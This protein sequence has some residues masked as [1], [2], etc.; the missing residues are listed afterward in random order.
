MFSTSKGNITYLIYIHDEF[1]KIYV[2]MIMDK[3]YEGHASRTALRIVVGLIMLGLLLADSVQAATL[4]VCNSGC[5]YSSIQDAIDAS[6]SGDT[7]LVQNGT[8]YENVNVYKQLT[9]RGIGM[10]EVYPWESGSTITLSANGIILE[11]FAETEAGVDIEAG[12]KVTSNNNILIGNNV[13]N[14]N[15]GISLQYSS[16]NKLIGNSVSNNAIGI[17]LW[18]S[19]SNMLSDNNVSNNAYGIYLGSSGNNTLIGNNV[20]NSYNRGIYLWYSNV[21]T[22]SSNNV[23][24]NYNKSVSLDFSSSNKIYNNF[25]NNINNMDQNDTRY[26]N[27]WNV[28]RISGINI[29]GGPYLGGNVWADPNGTGASQTCSDSDNDGI[30]DSFYM[31]N[32]NNIDY[33]P[34][35]YKPLNILKGDLNSNGIPA[36]AGDLVLMK[37][38]STGEIPADSRYDLNSNGQNADAGDLVLIKRASIGEIKL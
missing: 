18:D 16:S 37:R 26:S 21:N 28:V 33:L 15:Y 13:S 2:K 3:G 30:C 5:V 4:T 19:S 22:M 29:I 20:S 8:Y 36:D 38:A 23:S 11:E 24:N 31:L 6:N 1:F 14:N 27:V 34:L 10:P 25:F 32:N 9:L 17:H 7:I 12:I 35:A